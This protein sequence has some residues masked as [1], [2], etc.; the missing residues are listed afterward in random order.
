MVHVAGLVGR[1]AELEIFE[2]ACHELEQGRP[3]ALEV[4]GE[5]GIGKTR[6]LGELERRAESRGQLVL[7]GSASELE[8]DLPLAVF[9]DALDDYVD[10]SVRAEHDHSP[11]SFR[12]SLCSPPGARTSTTSATGATEPCASCSSCLPQGSRSY[13]FSTTSIGLTR[14]R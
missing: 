6:I 8:R 13:S 5:P 14:P 7:S 12:R 2:Q 3:A 4:V 9:V 11:P 1:Q 10:D